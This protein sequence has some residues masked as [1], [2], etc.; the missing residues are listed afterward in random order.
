MNY[1]RNRYRSQSTF[2][3]LIDSQEAYGRLQKE[4]EEAKKEIDGLKAEIEALIR[5]MARQNAESL[6]KDEN[7]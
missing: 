1:N 5:L 6:L 4:L 7:E 2:S 3:R